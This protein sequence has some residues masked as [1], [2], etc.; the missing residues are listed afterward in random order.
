MHELL[1]RILLR[2][3]DRVCRSR[4]S[5]PKQRDLG[6]VLFPIAPDGDVPL[7]RDSGAVPDKVPEV[8]HRREDLLLAGGAG[9]LLLLRAQLVV[10]VVQDRAEILSNPLIGEAFAL[11]RV[12]GGKIGPE[13]RGLVARC[14]ISLTG[15][16]LACRRSW[17]LR[18][19]LVVFGY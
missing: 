8:R 17:H 9:L 10:A 19:E 2:H 5:Q 1:C 14:V 3:P 13:K 16:R 15:L 12:E 4:R 6:S 18:T 11:L 7:R